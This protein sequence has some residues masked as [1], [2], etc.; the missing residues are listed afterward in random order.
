[1]GRTHTHRVMIAWLSLW[2]WAA[3]LAG[4]TTGRDATGN[5]RI[6]CWDIFEISLAGPSSGNP[7]V[8]IHL[9]PRFS[10][11]NKVFT[12]EG[13]YDS[14]GGYGIRFMPDAPGPWTYVTESNCKELDRKRGESTC[15]AAGP[16]NHG[17]M[18][19]HNTFQL[20]H[21]DG[22]PHFSVG[23]TCCAWAHQGDSGTP[24]QPAS[25]ADVAR[26]SCPSAA[27]QSRSQKSFSGRIH[28]GQS[29]AR[30]PPARVHGPD[31]SNSLLHL[32]V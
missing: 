23:T 24:G 14:D 3:L 10:Q 9:S 17:P 8:D 1:M 25:I 29:P 18:R 13:F 19:V 30:T 20:A 4:P 32:S 26:A 12:P 15:I 21:A 22:T 7:F 28:A 27:S 16:G 5:N 31:V 6:E 11:G 2:L